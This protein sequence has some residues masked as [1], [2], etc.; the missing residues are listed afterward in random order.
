M[1]EASVLVLKNIVFI[2]LLHRHHP[3]LEKKERRVELL[4][5]TRKMRKNN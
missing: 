2:L 4:K 3:L 1:K 5:A